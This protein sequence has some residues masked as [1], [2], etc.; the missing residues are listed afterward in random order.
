[1]SRAF[2][3]PETDYIRNSQHL[4]MNLLQG[5]DSLLQLDV[6]GGKLCLQTRLISQALHK[7]P[8]LSS[9]LVFGLSKLF[10]DILLC[11]SCER[12]ER[13]TAMELSAGCLP[14]CNQ[15][16]LFTNPRFFPNAETLLKSMIDLLRRF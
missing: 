11:A 2:I 4:L 5:I 12:G 1:M 6:I 7:I 3:S 13:S 16:A 9:H 14:G 15:E 10:F 8:Q